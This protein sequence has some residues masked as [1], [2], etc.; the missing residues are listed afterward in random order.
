MVNHMNEKNEKED[1]RVQKTKKA[2]RKTF[3]EMICEMGYK[4]ITIRELTQRATINRK[5]FYLHYGSLDDLLKELQDEV[6]NQFIR[7]DV[8]FRSRSDIRKLIRFFFEHAATMPQLYERV[9]C[10]GSN[11]DISDSIYERVMSYRKEKN[12]GAFSSDEQED[13]L[14]FAFFSSSTAVLYRQWVADG[15][16]YPIEDLIQ[17]ATRLICNGLD[18]YVSEE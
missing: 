16:K 5:T 1:L 14:A 18:N 6:V 3:E 9:L 4:D 10:S 7:Q 15:K 2:I 12:K 13:N 11:T 17:T 8:S